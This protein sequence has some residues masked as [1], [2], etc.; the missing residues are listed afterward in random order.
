MKILITENKM[1]DVWENS[2]LKEWKRKGY[3]SIDTTFM[4]LLRMSLSHYDYVE[5]WVQEWNKEHNIGPLK[6]FEDDGYKFH[7]STTSPHNY[8]LSTEPRTIT[9]KDKNLSGD[10]IIHRI[11]VDTNDKFVEVWFEINW[12]TIVDGGIA[13]DDLY[14]YDY[15]D[16]NYDEDDYDEITNEYRDDFTWLTAKY[17]REHYTDKMGYGMEVEFS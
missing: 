8:Y 16:D 1:L 7:N 3:A 17:I 10:V 2:F 12:E 15:D 13:F 11:D 9:L 6:Y 14:P 5:G 4:K